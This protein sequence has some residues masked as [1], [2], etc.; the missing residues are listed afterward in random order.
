MSMS[1]TPLLGELAEYV[2]VKFEDQAASEMAKEKWADDYDIN[3]TDEKRIQEAFEMF[4]EDGSGAISAQELQKILTRPG[5]SD[6]KL[7]IEEIEAM[8]E[9]IRKEMD[10]I[11]RVLDACYGEVK[12]KEDC[13]HQTEK[14]RRWKN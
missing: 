8:K 5:T 3:L 6:E 9:A 11:K 12:V 13:N 7:S 10:Q 14:K 4:D 2:G 1:L